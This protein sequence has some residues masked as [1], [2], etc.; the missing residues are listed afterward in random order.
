MLAALAVLAIAALAYG[1][2][3]A[4]RQTLEPHAENPEHVDALLVLYSQPAVYDAALDLLGAGVADRVFVSAHLGPDGHEK[5]CGEPAKADPRLHGV[6]VECFSPDPVTTQGEVMYAGE[7]MRALGLQ[8]LGVLTFGEHLERARLLA[9]RCWPEEEGTVSMYEFDAGYDDG[10]RARQA[11][12]AVLAY[13]KAGL[14]PGCG[15][16]LPGVVRWPLDL[17]KRALGMPIEAAVRTAGVR[18]VAVALAETSA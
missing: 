17:A 5:L 7:R 15:D 11:A 16:E 10:V 8:D 6:T 13:G 2:S 1:A 12:Y 3:W 14:T 4:A 18:P 9:Q